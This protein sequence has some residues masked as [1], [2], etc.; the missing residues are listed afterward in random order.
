MS[1]NKLAHTLLILSILSIIFH[2][3]VADHYDE[4]IRGK[5]IMIKFYNTKR[6]NSTHNTND[7]SLFCLYMS[8]TKETRWCTTTQLY[9]VYFT[10][11]PTTA[12]STVCTHNG[13]IV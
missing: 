3:K 13:N 12:R 10:P 7:V 1:R 5:I 4:E 8:V 6:G 2:P 9:D 11:L